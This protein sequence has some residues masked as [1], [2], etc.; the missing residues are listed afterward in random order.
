MNRK[1][2]VRIYGLGFGKAYIAVGDRAEEG[3]EEGS[4]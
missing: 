1:V 2:V 4:G 3:E